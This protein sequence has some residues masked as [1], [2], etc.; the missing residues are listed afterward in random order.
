MRG[1]HVINFSERT[2]DL[3][4]WSEICLARSKKMGYKK[5]LTGKDEIPTDK[6]NEKAVAEEEESGDD[7]AR[8]NDMSNQAFE[9]TTKQRKV[10]FCLVECKKIKYSKENFELVLKLE[11]NLLSQ[12]IQEFDLPILKQQSSDSSGPKNIEEIQE[13]LN[14]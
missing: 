6:K 1:I 13:T 3:E 4:G 2:S 9:V 7:I 12:E 14:H 5:L 10:A 11:R 8:L